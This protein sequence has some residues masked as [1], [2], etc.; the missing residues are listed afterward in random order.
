MK[1]L[2]E[3]CVLSIGDL[4]PILYTFV[5]TDIIHVIKWTTDRVMNHVN[6][7]ESRITITSYLH[8]IA[9]SDTEQA[10]GQEG[11]TKVFVTLRKKKQYPFPV[12]NTT[13]TPT[14]NTKS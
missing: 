10:S 5:D 13:P 11:K 14:C 12:P 7:H 9:T 4:S 6:S 8:H 2:C 3:K 1:N